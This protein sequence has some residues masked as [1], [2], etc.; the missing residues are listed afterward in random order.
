M[1]T[2]Y[3]GR[4]T[5]S[6]V[7]RCWDGTERQPGP[8]RR[9]CRSRSAAARAGCADPG[10]S[11]GNSRSVVQTAG[12]AGNPLAAGIPATSGYGGECDAA[13]TRCAAL[14]THREEARLVPRFTDRGLCC[15]DEADAGYK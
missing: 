12:E 4:G 11:C 9:C 3:E 13:S 15:A 2:L 6:V 5:E 8:G 14:W 7:V 10:G 1:R